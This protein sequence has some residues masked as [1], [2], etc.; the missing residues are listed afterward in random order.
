[1]ELSRGGTVSDVEICSRTLDGAEAAVLD[2]RSAFPELAG[3]IRPVERMGSY[4]DVIVITAG[5]QHEASLSPTDLL[6]MNSR[7]ALESV[8]HLQGGNTTFVLVGSPVDEVT[9]VF[10]QKRPDV[11]PRRIIG[12]GGELDLCRLR[13]VLLD[14]AQHVTSTVV[15]EHG[16]RVIPVYEGELEYEEI[17]QEVRTTLARIR[18]GT[19]KAR[20]L[21]SGIQLARLLETLNQDETEVHCVSAYDKNHDLYLTWPHRLGSAGVV[22]PVSLDLGPKAGVE[23]ERLVETRRTRIAE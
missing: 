14:R 7:L 3:K 16:A 8:A 19:G 12:F 9:E 6:E 10:A 2:A 11:D 1:M 13:A 23:L 20:N 5:V 4:L 22:E 21:S 18:T 17:A 15:G